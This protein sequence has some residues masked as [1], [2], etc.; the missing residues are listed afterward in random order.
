MY[1]LGMTSPAEPMRFRLTPAAHQARTQAAASDWRGG[2]LARAAERQ[3][4]LIEQARAQG[5]TR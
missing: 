4:K 3:A 5:S 1:G 2:A